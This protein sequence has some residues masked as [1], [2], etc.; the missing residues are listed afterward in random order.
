METR[1]IYHCSQVR[2]LCRNFHLAHLTGACN[3]FFHIWKRSTHYENYSAVVVF[4]T[5]EILPGIQPDSRNKLIIVIRAVYVYKY[6]IKLMVL[7]RPWYFRPLYLQAFSQEDCG[8]LAFSVINK[9]I[10]PPR[11]TT[12]TNLPSF[13]IP[14][15]LVILRHWIFLAGSQLVGS[16]LF[17]PLRNNAL[18]F[19]SK[20][21][22]H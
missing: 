9:E 16:Y 13:L 2:I 20:I 18:C 6:C 7:S 17:L 14:G 8:T 4:P 3:C 10:C 11:S 1:D 19:K 12:S 22:Q 5:P 15:P 21:L